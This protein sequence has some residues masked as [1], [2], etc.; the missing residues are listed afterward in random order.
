MGDV[1]Q[2]YTVNATQSMVNVTMSAT[3]SPS[4]ANVT[5]SATVSPSMAN[6]TMS[7]TVSPSMAN[8]TMS[9]TVSPSM[10]NVTMS[11]TVSPS[12]ANYS[13]PVSATPPLPSNC[14]RVCRCNGSDAYASTMVYNMTVNATLS[15]NMTAVPV[16][17]ASSPVDASS[18]DMSPTPSGV[19]MSYTASASVSVMSYNSS[20]WPAPSSAVSPPFMC[21][22]VS[23]CWVD[24][25][26]RTH[27]PRPTMTPYDSMTISPTLSTAAPMSSSVPPECSG[28]VDCNGDCD[29]S[30]FMDCDVC[31]EGNTGVASLRDCAGVC[32]ETANISSCGVCLGEGEQDP[33]LDCNNTCFGTATTDSCSACT[34][35]TTGLIADYLKD[36][37]GVCNGDNSTCAGCD[38][39]PNS[40][41]VFD[42]CDVYGGDGS[43]CTEIM[44]TIRQTIA[45]SQ[46]SI[47]V[48]GAGL[49]DGTET[50]C[51]L[52]D[53]QTGDMVVN[54]TA[55]QRNLTHVRCEF[56][57]WVNYT[58]GVY[59]LSVTIVHSNQ[60]NVR[61][62]K[63]LPVYY[64]SRSDLSLTNVIPNVVLKGDLPQYVTLNGSGLFNWTETVCYFGSQE[65][66]D[67]V[68]VNETHLQCK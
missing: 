37:C 66:R 7:A 32:N 54:A 52:Y 26:C 35:G 62:N 20:I 28:I 30:A 14:Y 8:V 12:M 61:T 4:M 57:P 34:G 1:N 46:P 10:A 44:A 33:F 47:W 6:V 15:V 56:Q 68:Y 23:T 2:T 3:V 27:F 42:A 50:V 36:E 51:G 18:Y 59:N 48:I 41:L 19:D 5:M 49:D 43:T 31:I 21:P 17:M 25:E 58:A 53:P 13:V 65:T 67:V 40:G 29:G 39:I 24:I 16:N 60:A 64:Y 45:S 9:A 22:N 55:S 38:G 11:A 63:S